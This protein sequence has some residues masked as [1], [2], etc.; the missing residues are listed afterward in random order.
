MQ[1]LL[2]SFFVVIAISFFIAP[3]FENRLGAESSLYPQAYNETIE[4]AIIKAVLWASDAQ[5]RR[6][7]NSVEQ[8]YGSEIKQISKKYYTCPKDIKA[9]AVVESLID[10]DAKSH[11]GAIGLMGVKK[12]TGK[13]MGFQD[14]EHPIN[15]LKAGTKYYRLLLKKFK[16]RELALAAYNL[17]PAELENR[18]NKGFNPETIDYIWKIR[19]VSRLVM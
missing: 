13:E 15:N 14:L 7:L 17:G 1:K 5:I 16:D 12:T 11:L 6:L 2:I 10:E 19:R 3:N 18:L 4:Q 9:I 8:K